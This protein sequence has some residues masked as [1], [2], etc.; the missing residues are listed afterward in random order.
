MDKLIIPIVVTIILIGI[1][2]WVFNNPDGIGN[3]LDQAG[4]NVKNKI[5]NATN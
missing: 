2:F 3:G 4:T 5:I 1:S